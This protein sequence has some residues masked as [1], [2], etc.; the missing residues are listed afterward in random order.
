MKIPIIEAEEPLKVHPITATTKG[1]GRVEEAIGEVGQTI[2]DITTRIEAKKQAQREASQLSDIQLDMVNISRNTA[3]E[4]QRKPDPDTYFSDWSNAYDVAAKERLAGIKSQNLRAQADVM[5]KRLKIS[6]MPQ[7]EAYGNRL[8]LE[9]GRA[10]LI[11]RTDEFARLGM[12]EEGLKATEDAILN[13]IISADDGENLKIRFAYRLDLSKAREEINR[14]PEKA[15]EILAKYDL[16]PEDKVSLSEIAERLAEKR[17][18]ERDARKVDEAIVFLKEPHDVM[19]IGYDY[20]GMI[21]KLRSVPFQKELGLTPK[22]AVQA[23]NLLQSEMNTTYDSIQQDFLK[24]LQERTLTDTEII[25]SALPATGLI[26]G[27]KEWW[28]RKL[29]QRQ[30]PQNADGFLHSNPRVYAETMVDVIK[31]PEM[32]NK[33][34]I[35]ALVGLSDKDGKP[36]GLKADDAL[37]I[38]NIHTQLMKPDPALAKKFTA[39]QQA[40][41]RLDNYRKAF[42]FVEPKKEGEIS[43]IE[44]VTNDIL[45]YS[46]QQDLLRRV[47]DGDDPFIALG[48]IMETYVKEKTK[49]FFDRVL[50]WVLPSAPPVPTLPGT[51]PTTPPPEE[52]EGK[53]EVNGV[54]WNWTKAKGWYR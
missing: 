6:E 12:K 52:K 46:V 15:E 10:G 38:W 7:Q 25:N 9:V 29:E 5:L 37:R 32:W 26:Q 31:R 20:P 17:Q 48:E 21:N 11:R 18:N 16:P 39:L 28:L 24:K 54:I 3:R 30:Q 19:G 23:Q 1:A 42:F 47:D 41:E 50:N 45:H 33:D 44:V 2:F 34:K 49:G 14:N 22:Q 27:D 53:Y 51:A 13:G 43:H 4:L 36:I 35:F 40:L 8:F